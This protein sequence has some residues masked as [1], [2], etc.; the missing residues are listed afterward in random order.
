M[1]QGAVEEDGLNAQ[2]YVNYRKI[3]RNGRKILASQIEK[4]NY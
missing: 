3:E 4:G 2:K 1:G